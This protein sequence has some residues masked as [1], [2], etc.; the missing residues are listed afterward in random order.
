MDMICWFELIA[1][2]MQALGGIGLAPSS[3]L[4]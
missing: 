1:Q 3:E 4:V 2:N